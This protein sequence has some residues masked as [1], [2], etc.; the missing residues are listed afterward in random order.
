[1]AMKIAEATRLAEL[2]IYAERP[3]QE[4]TKTAIQLARAIFAEAEERGQPFLY[5]TAE[6]WV[7]KWLPSKKF[8]LMRIPLNVVALPCEPKG[9]N[10]VLKKIHAREASPILVE[11]NKNQVG[12]A[13]HGFIPAVVCIDGKHRYKASMLRGDSHIVA[14]VGEEAVRE[15][16]AS[17]IQVD[18]GCRK[19]IH[20][21]GSGS[22]GGGG[23]APERTTPSSGAKLVAEGKKIKQLNVDK[24]YS[25]APPG[26]NCEEMVKA[27]KR[28]ASD[29]ASAF[30]ITWAHYKKYGTCAKSKGK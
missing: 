4:K 20:A 3:V 11:Y 24:I 14:W 18:C 23:P 17:G 2:T 7:K 28:T 25:V 13:M 9:E 10:L 19:K 12:K 22:S 30:K 6:K 29:E 15:M 8:T 27:L 5:I 26:E 21:L 16:H 1:M